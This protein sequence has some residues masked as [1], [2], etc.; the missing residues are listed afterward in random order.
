M[1]ILKT[2][3]V[4][5]LLTAVSFPVVAAQ[6]VV[7]GVEGKAPVGLGDMVDDAKPIKL[8]EGVALTLINANGQKLK[9][10][11]PHNGPLGGTKAT[12]AAAGTAKGAGL[13]MG[14]D[15]VKTLAG[16][17][18]SKVDAKSL[19]AFRAAPAK[20]PGP[21]MYNV[22]SEPN[23]C[24]DGSQK[25]K[26]WRESARKKA[27]VTLVPEAGGKSKT[28]VWKK[29]RSTLSWPSS[30]P[31]ESGSSYKAKVG[32]KGKEQTVTVH[33]VPSD[34]PT[35][36]HQA[37]WMVEKGCSDQAR[38]LVVTANIDHMIQDMEKAGQF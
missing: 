8:D 2:C 27:I 12:T 10:S 20:I 31:F 19:G 22:S 5:M 35:R 3:F 14:Y 9:I 30:V 32:K 18:K 25:P 37:A 6:L 13:N 26:L 11:G 36:A 4:S 7:V 38:L 24:L 29:G 17:F 23:Y 34:L 1:T 21:W 28:L 15:V 33:Q 16:L